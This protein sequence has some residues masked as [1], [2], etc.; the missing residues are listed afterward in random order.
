MIKTFFL[1]IML[2]THPVHVTLLSIDY[3]PEVASFNVFL[4]I[5]YDD[6]LLDSGLNNEKMLTMNF[7]GLEPVT[8]D[9]VLKYID[10]K[11]KIYANDQLLSGKLDNLKISDNELNM[12]LVYSQARRIR[13]LTVKNYIMTG[14]YKDQ[15]NMIIVRVNDFEEGV[16][17]TSEI[18]EQTFKIK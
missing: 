2:V 11:I 4:K 18:T 15:A 1:S 12:N 8:R 14:L 10:D 13:T 9:A 6:F 3:A 5:Y 16:K 7:S 17:L